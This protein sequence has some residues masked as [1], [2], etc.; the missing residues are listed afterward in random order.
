MAANGNGRI[1]VVDDSKEIRNILSKMLAMMGFEVALASDGN[2]GLNLFL[3]DHF[4]LI[5]TDL[6]MPGID[7]WSLAG[8]VKS[9]SPETPVILM[10][11][12]EKEKVMQELEESCVDYAMFKPFRFEEIE[13]TI[14]MT[15]E[16]RPIPD[17]KE[18]RLANSRP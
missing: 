1:L 5:F 9:R 2:E 12:S 7:G 13:R 10:T 17:E 16:E 8:N 3:Q 15:L 4:D 14:R 6:Q 11:G 18:N